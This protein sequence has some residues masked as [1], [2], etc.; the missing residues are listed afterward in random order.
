MP[1]ELL[2]RFSFSELEEKLRGSGSLLVSDI[3]RSV[4]GED[5][6]ADVDIEYVHE[7]RPLFDDIDIFHPS[8]YG[9]YS[10]KNRRGKITVFEASS[11][12][13]GKKGGADLPVMAI[14]GHELGHHLSKSKRNTLGRFLRKYHSRYNLWWKR[15]EA[16]AVQ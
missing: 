11:F 6:P 9:G 15:E 4:T 3:F 16:A 1:N 12:M 10:Y 14:F 5:I 8:L 13:F 7:H 2:K